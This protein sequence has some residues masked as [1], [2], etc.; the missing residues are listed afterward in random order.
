MSKHGP[1]TG[2]HILQAALKRF[3]N[4]GYA[5]TSVQQIVDDAN[6]SKPAL[7]YHFRDKAGLFQALVHEAFDARYR[8]LCEAAAKSDHIRGQLEHILVDLFDFIDENRELMRICFATMFAAPGEV[9]ENLN[10]A[11]KCERNLEF[12]HSLIEHARQKGELDDRFDSRELAFGFSGLANF[13]LISNLVRKPYAP[14]KRAAKQIVE[15]F[16][17]G[18][19]PKKAAGI[20]PHYEAV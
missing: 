6:V 8:V 3:A 5:A 12:M 15:L 4:A 19:S 10:Y 16:L 9:P 17:S 2:K 18:A 7:Y 13:Y 1:E 14:D 20:I 11:E